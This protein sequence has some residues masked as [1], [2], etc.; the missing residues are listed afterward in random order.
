MLGFISAFRIYPV[1]GRLAV[2]ALVLSALFIL[3]V[4]QQAFYGPVNE[5]Y[6][7]L[8]DV[9]FGL[10]IPRMVLAG[11]ILLFGLFPSLLLSLIE[12]ASIPFI[13]GLIR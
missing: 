9:T 4:V 10:G 6:V 8:S 2:S 13:E 3:R 12:T 5:K 7:G 1:Y 11:V